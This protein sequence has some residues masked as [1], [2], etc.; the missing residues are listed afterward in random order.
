MITELQLPTVTSNQGTDGPNPVDERNEQIQRAAAQFEG[1][2]MQQL[3]KVMR[4][5]TPEMF[6]GTGGEL[7]GSMFDEAFA[8]SMT[9]QGG[10]GLRDVIARS[11]GATQAAGPIGVRRT[12]ADPSNING[13]RVGPTNRGGDS[14]NGAARAAN[15]G[16]VLENRPLSGAP[17]EGATG[18]LQSAA[19]A[20]L[21]ESGTA[22]QW[23][24]EGALT[25]DDLASRFHTSEAGGEAYFRVRDARGY[26]GY[27]KCNLFAFELSRRAGFQVPVGPRPRGWGYVGPDYVANDAS[28]GSIRGSWARVATGASAELLDSAI[29]RG[30]SAFILAGS[31]HDGHRGHMGVIERVHAIDYDDAG[32]ITR[33]V[34]DGWEGRSQGAMHLTQRAWSTAGNRAGPGGRGGLGRIEILELQR[35]PAS[36][37]VETPLEEHTSAS[38]RDTF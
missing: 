9:Q 17:I 2:L 24:R 13:A 32:N 11:M 3:M 19:R 16:P 21:P 12:D 34:F 14:G 30:Q 29:V 1:L 27:Y 26:Q 10:F 33:I 25:E 7:Y 35:P 18:T 6:G 31:E 20:M 37:P 8:T 23:G 15:L 22:P 4:E 38:V 36:Q 28:D 5:S